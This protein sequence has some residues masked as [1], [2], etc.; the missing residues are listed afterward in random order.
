M[1]NRKRSN[2]HN[3]KGVALVIAL[4]VLF[5]L[6]ALA[7]ALIFATQSEMWATNNYQQLTQSRYAAETGAQMAK[8]WFE[9]GSYV[10]PSSLTNFNTTGTPVKCATGATGCTAG[11]A[12]VLGGSSSNFPTSS[13]ATSFSNAFTNT[14]VAGV[15]NATYSV[16]AQ[17]MQMPSTTTQV[18]Q[19]TSTGT[20]AGAKTAK[21][22]IVENISFAAASSPTFQYAVFATGSGCSNPTA[23]TFS[24][25][26]FTDGYNSSLGAYGGT[27]VNDNAGNVGTAGNV[28]MSGSALING[29][30]SGANKNVGGCPDT[31]TSSSSAGF[32]GSSGPPAIPATPGVSSPLGL[33]TVTPPA[34]S[35]PST[36]S[37]APP[38]NTSQQSSGDCSKI[39][40][41]CTVLSGSKVISLAP[42]ISSAGVV[43]SSNVYGD[44]SAS[45]GTTIHL[46]AGTYN[47]NSL[48]LSGTSPIIIDSGPIVINIQ[49]IK[50]LNSGNPYPASN[51]INYLQ[52]AVDLSG[53][54]VSNSAGSGTPA[55]FEIKCCGPAPAP[56][57]GT[58]P[59][60][61]YCPGLNLSGGSASTAV[62]YA[63]NAGITMSGGSAWYGA[64][65]GN[66]VNDSGGAAIH[67][68]TAL[69]NA[70]TMGSST[71]T[72]SVTGFTWS[73]N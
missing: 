60:Q 12:I 3:Q 2:Q 38:V 32:K 72:A 43:N 70:F 53:G 27:N 15:A 59:G 56:P 66:T 52:T 30:L 42:T 26:S 6:T 18:W 20:V 34:Y 64:I 24:S 51:P 28:V 11:N 13:V 48:V 61:N 9:S 73:K 19:I 63:P 44:I 25:S 71:P 45:G 46:S 10:S 54:S 8:N 1:K 37:P 4:V 17:L 57:N 40:A 62:V 65:I 55:N 36:L 68:D 47:I 50:Q 31:L 39:S 7:A 69:Q 41:G 49:G 67:Y 29:T 14:T 16:T 22:Q 58:N 33:Q 35:A 21:T 5:L 23:I